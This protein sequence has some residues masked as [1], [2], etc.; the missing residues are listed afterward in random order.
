MNFP[1]V[2]VPLLRSNYF[3]RYVLFACLCVGISL[4]SASPGQAQTGTI[5]EIA[6]EGSQR[7]EQSTVISYMGLKTGDPFDMSKVN[8]ALKSLYATGLFADVSIKRSGSKLIVNVVENAIIN[9][10]AFEGNQ[11]IDNED[12]ASE[13][14]LKPRLVFT[15]ARVQQDVKRILNIYQRTGRFSVRVEPKIIELSQKR[16]NL[17]FEIREGEKTGIDSISFV[18]N[19]KYNDGDLRSVIQT[20]ESKWWNFL[21]SND[22]YDP[23]RLAFDRELLR[24]YYLENGY[25]DFRVESAVAELTPDGSDFVI[26]FTVFEGERYRFGDTKVDS[27]ILNLPLDQLAALAPYEKGE[28]Y[29]ATDVETAVSNITDAI[30]E[31][32]YAFVDIQPKT[33][34]NPKTGVVNLTYEIGEGPKVYVE[35]IDIRGNFRTQDQVVRR[36]FKLVEGDA[37]NTAKLRRSRQRINNLGYFSK[38]D[39]KTLPGSTP[40]RTVVQVDVEEQSTGEIKFGFGFSSVDGPLGDI[41]IRERNLLGRG[42]DLRLAFKASGKSKE[43]DL[44]FTEPYFLG[45]P[46]AAGIDLYRKSRS[47]QDTSSFSEKSLGGNLRLGYNISEELYQSWRYTLKNVNIYD[48]ASDASASVRSE[49]G[50]KLHSEISQVLTLDRLDSRIAPTEGYLAKMNTDFAGLGGDVRYARAN[51]EAKYFYSPYEDVIVQASLYSGAIN[52]LGDD[53]RLS[54]RYFLGGSRV[55]GF[56]TSGIGPRD[57]EDAIGGKYY[58]A[59]SLQATFPIG[60]PEELGVT[61]RVFTDFGSLFGVDDS[62]PASVQTSSMIRSSAGLGI[63]WRSPFGQIN[64]DLGFALSK[65]DFDKTEK[66]KISFGTSF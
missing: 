1:W 3:L 6:V 41:S 30:G 44:G 24:R 62:A 61:G 33:D 2:G 11:Q 36:E 57:G 45:R 25:A 42:Q 19:K 51:A 56:A 29:D 9:E 8:K 17:V 65:E 26:T 55:R 10:I 53:V 48:V 37:F 5:T 16:V 27:R 18:G 4:F 40:D 34:K 50:E 23:D 58:Y 38:V 28:W 7:V 43:V 14:Q 12:L 66:F 22:T 64:L 35:K 54:D 60:F 32:G 20:S 52:G 13:I 39:V 47:N 21:S 63:G 15:P 46:L 49:E 31:R 59:G